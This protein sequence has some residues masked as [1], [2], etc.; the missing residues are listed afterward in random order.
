ML[1]DLAPLNLIN[2][3]FRSAL[4]GYC[5]AW[6][7]WVEASEG[8]QKHGMLVKGR[9]AGEPVRSPYLAIVNQ[10]L[11]QMK[12]FLVEFGLTPSA[13]SRIHV[14]KPVEESA[15]QKLLHGKN[16]S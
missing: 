13:S 3:L 1:A 2:P 10:S 8:L 15:F 5:D 11:E 9:L 6:S 7:R 14:E 16:A 12:G 4:A